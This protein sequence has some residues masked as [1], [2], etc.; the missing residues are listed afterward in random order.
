[1]FAWHSEAWDS[2]SKYAY[3]ICILKHD[4]LVTYVIPSRAA[5]TVPDAWL[6]L[7]YYPTII[8]CEVQVGPWG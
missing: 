8:Y 7:Q 1:M 5:P 6:F 4:K 2:S 3:L